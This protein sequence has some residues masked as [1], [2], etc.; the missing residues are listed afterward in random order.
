MRFTLIENPTF[1][2]SDHRYLSSSKPSC[3]TVVYPFRTLS[4]ENVPSVGLHIRP[5]G[6]NE[7]AGFLHKGFP[8]TGL[9]WGLVL[10][11]IRSAVL[12]RPV[13]VREIAVDDLSI[14]LVVSDLR[15]IDILEGES[16]VKWNMIKF[17]SDK[18]FS[19]DIVWHGL[20]L[21]WQRIMLDYRFEH[22]T[23]FVWNRNIF[24]VEFS[25]LRWHCY[26]FHNFYL[27]NLYSILYFIVLTLY[28]NDLSTF[29]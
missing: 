5:E 25:I 13:N 24:N 9:L 21:S 29:Q 27:D 18:I 19:L 17:S 4:S 3:L 23:F 28:L 1:R 14:L 2:T 8:G 7:W 12:S 26:L 16:R 6:F 22:I 10:G 11:L 15:S 20:E